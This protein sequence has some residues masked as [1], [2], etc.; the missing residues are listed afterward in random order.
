MLGISCFAENL[1]AYE[2]ALSY[3]ELTFSQQILPSSGP[4][5]WQHAYTEYH[6]T[7][8]TYVLVAVLLVKDG[9]CAT[10]ALKTSWI[11]HER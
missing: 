8:V 3:I 9:G 5:S 2:E 11:T 7:T 1:L 4:S 6:L 10:L